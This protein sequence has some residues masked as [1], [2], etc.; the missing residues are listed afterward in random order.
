MS[1]LSFEMLLGILLRH[2]DTSSLLLSTDDTGDVQDLSLERGYV[3]KHH[4]WM[5]V[6][7]GNLPWQWRN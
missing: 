5:K 2:C 4:E 7:G 1:Y 6:T 3:H